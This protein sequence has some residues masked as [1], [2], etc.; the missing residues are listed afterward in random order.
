MKCQTC[1]TND[2]MDDLTTCY[3]CGERFFMMG[4]EIARRHTHFD[5]DHGCPNCN[6]NQYF[7]TKLDCE[8]CVTAACF[9]GMPLTVKEA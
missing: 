9:D 6:I 7:D 3:E 2:A 1:K 4:K 5:P 8:Q